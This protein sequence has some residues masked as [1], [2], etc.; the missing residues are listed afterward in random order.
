VQRI[1]D[2]DATDETW[3]CVRASD[4]ELAVR[5]AYYLTRALAVLQKLP[6]P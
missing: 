1:T 6:A 2:Q 5:S 3:R 4:L